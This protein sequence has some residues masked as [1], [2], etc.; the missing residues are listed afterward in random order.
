MRLGYPFI[1]Q[2][3]STLL[4][5]KFRLVRRTPTRKD[6]KREATQLCSFNT[7]LYM[8]KQHWFSSVKP[9]QK[10]H[11][12]SWDDN[13]PPLPR[14]IGDWT[15]G[16]ECIWS[17]HG[18]CFIFS[19]AVYFLCL[20]ASW[21]LFRQVE[22]CSATATGGGQTT[23]CGVS[24]HWG[25]VRYYDIDGD[26]GILLQSRQEGQAFGCT[27]EFDCRDLDRNEMLWMKVSLISWQ[28]DAVGN[29][30]RAH[31]RQTVAGGRGRGCLRGQVGIAERAP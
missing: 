1:P 7:G 28:H 27:I 5:C 20:R 29:R 11:L 8:I 31:A 15:S 24:R 12:Q 21:I 13:A 2:K 3:G 22:T 9:I 4:L 26:K 30:L 23:T 14:S 6:S 17:I 10:E 18:I 19:S 25:V 16:P